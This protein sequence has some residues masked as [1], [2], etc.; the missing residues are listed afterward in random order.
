MLYNLKCTGFA[1]GSLGTGYIAKVQSNSGDKL[2]LAQTS[3]TNNQHQ[4]GSPP[5][6]TPN[7]QR[8]GSALKKTRSVSASKRRTLRGQVPSLMDQE[9]RRHQLASKLTSADTLRKNQQ[10]NLI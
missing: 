5:E 8:S 9:D 3:R 4:N 7:G 2:Y 6:L 10:S 1:T